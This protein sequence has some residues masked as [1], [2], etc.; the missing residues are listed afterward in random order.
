MNTAKTLIKCIFKYKG[1]KYNIEDIMPHC[2]E[3]ETAIFLYKYGN[4][5]DD[6]YRAALIRMK[7][8][9]DEIPK[10]SKGSKE[11]ELV[12]IDVKCN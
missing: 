6:I 8:G 4:Y 2:L 3:K 7:Y 5:S 11:I 9:D 10:L 1:K 12:N